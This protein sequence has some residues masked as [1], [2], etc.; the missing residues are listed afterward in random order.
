MDDRHDRPDR[1]DIVVIGAGLAGLT[2]AAV[3]ADQPGAASWCSTPT[4]PAA[5]PAP[6]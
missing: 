2:A 3:A 6:T 4:P 1:F 5:R